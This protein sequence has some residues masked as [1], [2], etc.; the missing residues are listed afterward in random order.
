ME[1]REGPGPARGQ[2]GSSQRGSGRRGRRRLFV[3]ALLLGLIPLF[4]LFGGGA[5]QDADQGGAEQG[6]RGGVGVHRQSADQGAGDPVGGAGATDSSRSDSASL[7]PGSPQRDGSAAEPAEPDVAPVATHPDVSGDAQPQAPASGPGVLSAGEDG[8]VS[9][10]VADELLGRLALARGWLTEGRMGA[11]ADALVRS[12]GEASVAAEHR[13]LQRAFQDASKAWQER[14]VVSVRKG[15][16]PKAAEALA[17]AGGLE[18]R[19]VQGQIQQL[20]DS[21][22]WPEPSR[23]ELAELSG[24]AGDVRSAWRALA[25]V[26]PG[27]PATTGEVV[28]LSAQHVSVRVLNGSVVRYPRW[29]RTALEIANPDPVVCRSQAVACREANA[30]TEAWLWA[31]A[32]VESQR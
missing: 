5:N 29:S 1:L 9:A 26:K 13:A 4:W 28:F 24:D 6:D 31:A 8:S 22:G 21:F 10:V 27:N 30:N 2:G 18:H 17:A 25:V 32:L 23:S 3:G 14:L 7:Q 15:S 19:W 20:R 12:Q 16:I 11:V